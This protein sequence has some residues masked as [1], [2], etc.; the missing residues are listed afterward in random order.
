LGISSDI[1]GTLI[2]LLVRDDLRIITNQGKWLALRLMELAIQDKEINDVLLNER[3]IANGKL[4]DSFGKLD[5]L[6]ER[7]ELKS[8][9]DYVAVIHNLFKIW[10]MQREVIEKDELRKTRF[11]G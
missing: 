3:I 5:D 9:D 1:P 8:G 10:Q 2:E 7:Y 11:Y 6:M 4:A